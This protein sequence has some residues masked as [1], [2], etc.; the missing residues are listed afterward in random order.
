MM[1]KKSRNETVDRL[2][3]IARQHIRQE[4]GCS[5][6][7]DGDSD[8]GGA[9]MPDQPGCTI[10]LL[11]ERLRV[12]AAGVASAVNPVNMP[13]AFMALSAAVPDEPLAL[14]LSIGKYWGPAPR[15]LTV[16]FTEPTPGLL[17]ARILEHM[18]AWTRCCGIG[19]R[20]TE[21]TGQVRISRA[22]SGYWSYLGTDILLI[23]KNRPTMNLQG[24]SM[25]TPESEY[26]RVVRHETGHTLGFPHEH[27][28]RELVA[29]I[30]RQKAY[31][32]FGATQGWTPA[33]VDA[34]VLTPLDQASILGTPADETSIMCYQLPGSITK[35]G[36]GIKGGLDIN[37][38]DCAFAGKVYPRGSHAPAAHDALAGG[39]FLDQM[40]DDW[41]AQEDVDVES[42][43]E[44]LVAERE[45]VD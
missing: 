43:I 16:S 13:Q 27:M 4:R 32:Y 44:E 21:G 23:P 41:S 3:A 1:G 11:P 19:F 14:T 37:A 9:A 17:R 45:P 25:A 8:G 36:V 26:R 28:R 18:N 42:L 15:T 24:F 10:R 35:N 12:D 6:G 2:M 22:G 39:A 40:P 34:Q 20:L 7:G 30:D 38:T 31:A 29:R 5:D 33:E